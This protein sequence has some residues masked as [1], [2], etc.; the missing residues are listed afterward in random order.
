MP[1][2]VFDQCEVDLD[3][4]CMYSVQIFCKIASIATKRSYTVGRKYMCWITHYCPFIL[5]LRRNRV[6]E[7]AKTCNYCMRKYVKFY[8]SHLSLCCTV[9]G[10]RMLN[11]N[12]E[13]AK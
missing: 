7:P 13:K 3:S 11:W 2:S 10:N 12:I 8:P 4:C 1:K 9:G 5:G 6:S